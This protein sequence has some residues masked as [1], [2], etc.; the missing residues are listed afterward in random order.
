MSPDKLIVESSV[1][2]K[3]GTR[4]LPQ[5]DWMAVVQY[6]APQYYFVV[7]PLSFREVLNSLACGEEQ[8]VIPNLKRISA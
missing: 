2:C 7:S 3:V 4:S 1:A 5:S 6:L 8:Y